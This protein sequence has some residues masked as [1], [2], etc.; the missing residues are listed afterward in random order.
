MKK[1]LITK[2]TGGLYTVRDEDK[3]SHELKARGKFRHTNE[4]PMVG[5]NVLYDGKFIMEIL[6]RKNSLNRPPLANIDQAILINSCKEPDFSF[7]LLDRFLLLIEHESITPIIVITKVDLMND[8]E[9]NKLKEDMKYYETFYQVIYTSTVT[10]EGADD[11]KEL[12]KDK[13][14]VFAGQTGAGKSSLL[15]VLEPSFNL[16]TDIISKALGRGKHTTRHSEMYELFEGLVA[17]TPGFS[18]L[19]FIDIKEENV[20]DCF[21]DFFELSS[22]CK[23]RGCHHLNEPKCKVKQEL[24]AGNILP[25]RYRNYKL[26]IQ[27]IKEQKIKY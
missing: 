8:L 24:E 26:I 6:E 4:S 13:I 20:P 19:D 7:N 3:N 15:N 14:N 23:F 9:L 5:D 17:D 1:G 25:S 10:K 16:K 12:F 21:V 18:K 22:E 2:L 27:E 11:F